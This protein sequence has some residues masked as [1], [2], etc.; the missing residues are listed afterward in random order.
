M[1]KTCL[2]SVL[3][4]LVCAT[5]FQC[6]DDDQPAHQ[7]VA[8]TTL[9]LGGPPGDP[10]GD[11]DKE[12]IAIFTFV[13]QE[14]DTIENDDGGLVTLVQ[15]GDTLTTT[16]F[17]GWVTFAYFNGDPTTSSTLIVSRDGYN[18]ASVDFIF[19]DLESLDLTVYLYPVP[20]D[21]TS[22][23]DRSSSPGIPVDK[24]DTPPSF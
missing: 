7:K 6:A 22:T 10:G 5:L 24:S 14:G 16:D 8:A 23:N 12:T 1:L 17:S 2:W 21:T 3:L 11:P 9:I 13:V 19:D 20:A 4:L 15:D 18:P